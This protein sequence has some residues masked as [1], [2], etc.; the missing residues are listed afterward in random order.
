[1][2]RL[3]HPNIVQV[4]DYGEHEGSPYLIM[5]YLPGGTLKALTGTPMDYRRAA[6][7]LIPIADALAYAHN[8]GIIHRDIKP[9]NILITASGTPMLSDFGIAKILESQDISLTNTG[10]G[11]GTP[12]YMAPEQWKNK[13]CPQTDIYALG[14]IFYELVTGRRPY[15]AETPAAIAV[16]QATEPLV[17]PRTFIS[18]LPE[19]VERVIF[20]TLAFKPENRY[21]SMQQFF[22]VLNNL[23]AGQPTHTPN[24]ADDG[25][26]RVDQKE[27]FNEGTTQDILDSSPPPIQNRAIDKPS[28]KRSSLSKWTL[29]AGAAAILVAVICIILGLTLTGFLSGRNNESSQSVA[30]N[31]NNIPPESTT[32]FDT[33]AITQAPEVKSSATP[34]I[35]PTV[36]LGMGSTKTNNID[37]AELV[38]VPSGEFIMGSNG[39]DSEAD[40][41]PEHEVYLDAYWIY[42]NEVTHAQFRECL[43]NGG[44]SDIHYL[45][46]SDSYPMIY[47]SWYEAQE[48][49]T[50]A[51]GR[52]PTEAEWEKAARGTD[53]RIY[54]WGNDYPNSNYAN[55][56]GSSIGSTMSVGSYPLGAS[57]YGVLDMAGNVMEWVN[58]WY[59]SDY[60]YNSPN[61]NP[62]G[63]NNGSAR[64]FRGSSYYASALKL[65]V[66]IRHYRN[67]SDS[68]DNVGFRCVFN[69]N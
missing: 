27:D 55:F 43:E 4:M 38:Y 41:R 69:G 33:H 53:G 18:N 22:S 16:K 2:A 23:A 65:R 20:K 34:T 35:I 25:Y 60:Y 15:D 1:M 26:P 19:E 36:S 48:Y 3:L 58:D 37:Q 51:G 21:P 31:D 28:P 67:P 59:A 42:K 54:P 49:C 30:G 40:E 50:W 6:S 46:E 45:V 56:S 24:V 66:T 13:V 39:S 7:L 14:T 10:F 11:V 52:L 29:W 12:H 68:Y 8:Q 9:A 32:S 44:C 47:V 63:P 61:A 17:R 64:V 57:P 62:T 5:P